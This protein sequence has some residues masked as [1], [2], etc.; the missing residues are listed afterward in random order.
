M[1]PSLS[2][3]PNCASLE[4]EIPL[5]GWDAPART[6]LTRVA[7]Q[8]I[9]VVRVRRQGACQVALEALPNCAARK[10]VYGYSAYAE[11]RSVVADDGVSL[12]ASFPLGAGRLRASV[13]HGRGVRA[14]VHLAGVQRLPVGTVIDRADLTGACDGATHV[15]T[16]VHR[17]AYTMASGSVTALRAETPL[18]PAIDARVS[19]LESAGKT[20]SCAAAAQLVQDCD[21]PLR[22]EIAP[23]DAGGAGDAPLPPVRTDRPW[24]RPGPALVVPE[25]KR[26]PE[27]MVEILGG[28]FT[29]GDNQGPAIERPEHAVEVRT[30]CL[31]RTEVTVA[32]YDKCMQASICGRWTPIAKPRTWVE[33]CNDAAR[34]QGN[35]PRNCIDAE[36]AADYCA[37]MGKRLPTEQEWEYAAKGGARNLKFPWGNEAPD[38]KRACYGLDR[39]K[40]T[41]CAV[42]GAGIEAS[43]AY[44]L[45]GNLSELVAGRYVPYPGSTVEGSPENVVWRGGNFTQGEPSALRSAARQAGRSGGPSQTIGFRCA[46]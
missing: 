3:E 45:A 24:S 4:R 39:N 7:E 28:T 26:C 40:D 2:Q 23:I 37:W 33:R 43:G 36:R 29:M 18:T 19:I 15:V 14:D 27:G 38:R 8:A 46:R 44:D 12:S 22:V 30:F 42:A 35:H 31:D 32:A 17:G 9:A 25:G 20:A 21:V 6:E 5:I 13:G 1:T 41:S 34:G 11:T 16:A 10:S